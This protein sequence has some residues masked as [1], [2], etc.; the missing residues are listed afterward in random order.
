[1]IRTAIS[2]AS[3]FAEMPKEEKN[4]ISHRYKA[5]LSVKDY[6]ADSGFAFET[7]DSKENEQNASNKINNDPSVN[8]E[9]DGSTPNKSKLD[10]S[11]CPNVVCLWWLTKYLSL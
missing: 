11:S 6:F 4:K 3:S 2:L 1:M 7:D 9:K 8:N 10:F 5:L